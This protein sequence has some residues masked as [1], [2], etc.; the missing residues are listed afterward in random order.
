MLD[1][2]TISLIIPCKNEAKGLALLLKKI[3]SYVDEVVVVDNGSLDNTVKVAKKFGAKVVIEKRQYKQI[4]YG[5]ARQ[6]GIKKATGDYLVTLDGDG[7]YPINSIKTLVDYAKKH[8]LDF[9]V[10]NR[11]PL[12]NPRVVSLFRRLGTLILNLEASILYLY[13]IKDILSGMW[14][15]TKQA[16]KQLNLRCG[17]WNLSPEIKLAALKH[18]EINF[19][20]YHVNHFYRKHEHSKQKIFATGIDHFWYILSRRFTIDN[21]LYRLKP[22]FQLLPEFLKS[23]LLYW[24]LKR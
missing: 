8:R 14:L 21:P 2:K 3:P 9:V 18:P 22:D 11:Y 4:G 19:G 17:G 12:T 16:A 7:T 23:L 15:V 13:P 1:N 20:Q 6:A 10:G 5:F 24:L